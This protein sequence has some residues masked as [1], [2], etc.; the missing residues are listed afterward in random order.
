MKVIYSPKSNDE[1]NTKFNITSLNQIQK[2][3]EL[4]KNL[5]NRIINRLD[6]L[7]K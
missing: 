5:K 6:K 7:K 3:I 2:D 1:I 4:I